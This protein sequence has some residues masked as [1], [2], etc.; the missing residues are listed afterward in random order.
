MS[1]ESPRISKPGISSA[2]T[3]IKKWIQE[4]A[5]VRSTKL[6][7]DKEVVRSLE[8]WWLSIPENS[9]EDLQPFSES[10]QSLIFTDKSRQGFGNRKECWVTSASQSLGTSSRNRMPLSQ[11]LRLQGRYKDEGTMVEKSV[12]GVGLK[13]QTKGVLRKTQCKAQKEVLRITQTPPTPGLN[14]FQWQ[15]GPHLWEERAGD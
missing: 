1:T 4:T 15:G 11:E 14:W 8:P 9:L 2:W 5:K 6:A 12:I 10:E 7:T 3:K 13:V